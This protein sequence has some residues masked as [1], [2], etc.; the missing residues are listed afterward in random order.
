MKRLGT[1]HLSSSGETFTTRFCTLV[2]VQH[3]VVLGGMGPPSTSPELV[4]AVCNAGGLG[5]L[6]C[7]GLSPDQVRDQTAHIRAL[8][9][10]PFGL[11]LL[12]FAASEALLAAVLAERPPV[13][14]F[15]WPQSDAPLG[16]VFA[17][18]HDVGCLV[19][20]MVS[21]TP[22]ARRAVEAGADIIVAQGTEGGGHVGVMGTMALV[23]Q[24]VDA[25]APVPVL[26][27]GGIA[28]G[29][30]L[31]AALALGAEGALLGT[32]FLATQE[33]SVPDGVKQAILASDGHDT[34][35]TEIPDIVTARV[36]PGAFARTWRNGLLREWSG[37]EWELRQRQPE[38]AAQI[39]T[40]R[41]AGDHDRVPILFGQDAGL[42]AT[43]EPAADVV[44]RIVREART[45]IEDRL[46][47]LVTQD[48][49]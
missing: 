19:M 10:A 38:V 31:A 44:A 8:T 26:A 20:H 43:I 6:G 7:S 22:E 17:R 5:I 40:A 39:A 34:D 25:I 33:A 28:D 45:I 30:G 12:L 2:G 32:R 9:T 42:I 18:A 13:A 21:Q 46:P 35:L 3:P 1:N 48:G 36:W 15:A 23:P 11:N 16:E 4:A 24:V 14:S 49:A 29:R 47:R 41:A 27:A 37:R